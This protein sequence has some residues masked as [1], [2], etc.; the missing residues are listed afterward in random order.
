MCIRDRVYSTPH[1]QATAAHLL[2]EWGAPVILQRVVS[3]PEFNVLGIGD[4]EGG[5]IAQCSI[6]KTILSDKGK[7][8]GGIT[9]TDGRLTALCEKLVRE[10]RWNGPFE[11]ELIYDQHLEEY[12]LIEICLLYTSRCV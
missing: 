1:A 6:R 11:I 7:G 12:V 3:G 8:M 4:G 2:A 5:V 10:L 9:V